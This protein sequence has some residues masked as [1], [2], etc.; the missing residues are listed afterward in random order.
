MAA[1]TAEIHDRTLVITMGETLEYDMFPAFRQLYENTGEEI[2]TYV[3]DFQ[4]TRRIDSA[5]LGVLLLLRQFAGDA[6][7]RVRLI[8]AG[9]QVKNTLN[10]VNF[11][12]FFDVV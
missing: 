2:T 12:M 8:N 6:R 5:A 7:E 4:K 11:N 9:A 1:P 3:V 10:I